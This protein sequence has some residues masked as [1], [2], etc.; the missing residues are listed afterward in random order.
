[1]VPA[2]GYTAHTT[3]DCT[4]VCHWTRTKP[5]PLDTSGK[6]AGIRRMPIYGLYSLPCRHGRRWETGRDAAAENVLHG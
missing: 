2:A 3:A 5:E 4:C 1:M 6:E